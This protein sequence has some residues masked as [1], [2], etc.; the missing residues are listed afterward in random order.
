MKKLIL[1]LILVLITGSLIIACPKCKIIEAKSVCLGADVMVKFQATWSA[2]DDDCPPDGAIRYSVSYDENL[3]SANSFSS[4]TIFNPPQGS[5]TVSAQ[6]S[7]TCQDSSGTFTGWGP[8]SESASFDV[9]ELVYEGHTPCGYEKPTKDFSAPLNNGDTISATIS[10]KPSGY[11][12]TFDLIPGDIEKD[13]DATIDKDGKITMG[14][15]PGLMNFEVSIDLFKEF[16][17]SLGLGYANCCDSGKAVFYAPKK[18]TIKS[19]CDEECYKE[20][21]NTG[22][23]VLEM[24][25]VFRKNKNEINID[26]KIADDKATISFEIE[27][28]PAGFQDNFSVFTGN[29]GEGDPKVDVGLNYS[30]TEAI[31]KI[32]AV[33]PK[34]TCPCS[35]KVSAIVNAYSIDVGK[36]SPETVKDNPIAGSGFEVEALEKVDTRGDQTENEY[37]DD[38]HSKLSI[39][40]D[41]PDTDYKVELNILEGTDFAKLINETGDE[42]TEISENGLK[43]IN[44]KVKGIKYSDIKNN[45]KTK[46]KLTHNSIITSN[47]VDGFMKTIVET[48]TWDA[49][50]VNNPRPFVEITDITFVDAEFVLVKG[51]IKDWTGAF[52]RQL[53]NNEK[54]NIDSVLS[55][56]DISAVQHY[57]ANWSATVPIRKGS[58]TTFVVTAVFQNILSN[59]GSSTAVISITQNDQGE[60]INAVKSGNSNNKPNEFVDIHTFTVE[61]Y[62]ALGDADKPSFPWLLKA[63]SGDTE[64]VEADISKVAIPHYVSKKYALM[65]DNFTQEKPE[66]VLKAKPGDRLINLMECTNEN[67]AEYTFCKGIYIGLDEPI[68]SIALKPGSEINID[69]MVGGEYGDETTM[70]LQSLYSSNDQI[71]TFELK[72]TRGSIEK[73]S[74]DYHKYLNHNSAPL[75]VWDGKNH[76]GQL[77]AEGGGELKIE[78]DGMLSEEP[79]LHMEI[80]TPATAKDPVN[81]RPSSISWSNNRD[82]FYDEPYKNK[83]ELIETTNKNLIGV[84]VTN[85]L[86]MIELESDLIANDI[87]ISEKWVADEKIY[88]AQIPI[89]GVVRDVLANIDLEARVRYVSA[90]NWNNFKNFME[91]KTIFLE[92]MRENVNPSKPNAHISFFNKTLTYELKEGKNYIRIMT[93]RNALGASSDAFYLIHTTLKIVDLNLNTTEL[94]ITNIEVL[95]N[96]DNSIQWSPYFANI[97]NGLLAEKSVPENI[98]IFGAKMLTDQFYDIVSRGYNFNE[99]KRNNWSSEVFVLLPFEAKKPNDEYGQ[100]LGGDISQDKGFISSSRQDK[101]I[102][103]ANNGK[104]ELNETNVFAVDLSIESIKPVDE[105][106]KGFFMIKASSQS[107]TQNCEPEATIVKLKLSAIIKELIKNKKGDLTLSLIKSKKT[108]SVAFRLEL[109]KNGMKFQEIKTF[110]DSIKINDENI[111]SIRVL[112]LENGVADL[113]LSYK[114]ESYYTQDILRLK[115][116][117]LSFIKPFGDYNGEKDI[118]ESIKLFEP[119]AFFLNVT[120]EQLP[121]SNEFIVSGSV[122]DWSGDIESNCLYYNGIPLPNGARFELLSQL[123]LNGDGKSTE[124]IK[125]KANFSFKTQIPNGAKSNFTFDLTYKNKVGYISEYISKISFLRDKNQVIDQITRNDIFQHPKQLD[126]V[127]PY[128]YR[129]Y[130]FDPNSEFV[131]NT[132][133]SYSINGLSGEQSVI[134]EPKPWLSSNHYSQ[135]LVLIADGSRGNF[136]VDEM[137]KNLII[138]WPGAKMEVSYKQQTNQKISN[139]SIA[140]G[141][142]TV[143]SNKTRPI[144][145]VISNTNRNLKEN[146]FTNN[147]HLVG[148]FIKAKCTAEPKIII[149]AEPLKDQLTAIFFP[150]IQDLT[151]EQNLILKQ[152]GHS[153]NDEDFYYYELEP[154][155]GIMAVHM[156]DYPLQPDIIPIFSFYGFIKFKSD[157]YEVFTKVLRTDILEGDEKL[158]YMNTVFDYVSF[159]NNKPKITNFNL[160]TQG[161]MEY[162]NGIATQRFSLDIV[163]EDAL[164]DFTSDKDGRLA[165]VVI[166]KNVLKLDKDIALVRPSESRPYPFSK[167]VFDEVKLELKEG[168]NY[169]LL[170]TGENILQRDAVLPIKIITKGVNKKLVVDKILFDKN[171]IDLN[172]NQK[173]FAFE[174]AGGVRL[175]QDQNKQI[176]VNNNAIRLG[177]ENRAVN[178]FLNNTYSDLYTSGYHIFTPYSAIKTKNAPA[179]NQE[180]L[181]LPYIWQTVGAPIEI[182]TYGTEGVPHH[183]ADFAIIRLQPTTV[184]K[185]VLSDERKIAIGLFTPLFIRN[186]KEKFE[187]RAPY[188]KISFNQKAEFD[189]PDAK[190]ILSLVG[191]NDISVFLNEQEILSKNQKTFELDK[192]KFDSSGI[193][194][195][196]FYVLAYEKGVSYIKAEFQRKSS[197]YNSNEF[198]V[199]AHDFIRL[200]NWLDDFIDLDIDSDNNNYYDLPNRITL[201]DILE[202]DQ[203]LPGKYVA[204]NNDDLDYDGIPDYADGFNADGIKG[205]ADDRS[206]GVEFI[207]L[208]LEVPKDIQLKDVSIEFKYNHSGKI[209]IKREGDGSKLNPYSFKNETNSTMRIWTKDGREIRNKNAVNDKDSG[210]FVPPNVVYKDIT[211]LGFKGEQRTITLY[212]EG[213]LAKNPDGEEIKVIMTNLNGVESEDSVRVLIYDLRLGTDGDRDQTIDFAKAIDQR[214]DFWL[215]D[216]MDVIW[217]NTKEYVLV[218]DAEIVEDDIFGKEKYT[219][220]MLKDYQTPWIGQK[221]EWEVINLK[222]KTVEA[223]CLRD[224]EDFAKLKLG[225]VNKHLVNDNTGFYLKVRRPIASDLSIGVF[226]AFDETLDYLI[227]PQAGKDQ[228]LEKKLFSINNN[229]QKLGKD[230]FNFNSDNFFLFEGEHLG[231]GQLVFGIK[232][233]GKVLSE[234]SIPI[235]LRDIKSYYQNYKV[236][237]SNFSV[238]QQVNN[239]FRNDTPNEPVFVYVH[240][241]NMEGVDALWAETIYKRL[242]WQKFNGH[243]CLFDWEDLG[244]YAFDNSEENAWNSADAL[245]NTINDIRKR[246]HQ[247]E[248]VIL[249]HSQGNIVVGEYLRNYLNN[250][251]ISIKAYISTQGA[252]SAHLYD[253]QIPDFFT[254]IETPNIYGYYTDGVAGKPYMFENVSKTRIYNFYNDE[255]WALGWW[256]DANILRPNNLKGYHYSEGDGILNTYFPEFGDAFKQYFTKLSLS[257]RQER[258]KIFAQCSES[259][260]LAIGAIKLDVKGF[261]GKFDLQSNVGY[262]NQHYSH[263][264]QFRSNIIDENLFW[265]EVFEILNQ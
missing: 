6:L 203:K 158:D 230:K 116:G 190:I 37:S 224:L 156:K 42:V 53:V 85:V 124:P 32:F 135:R 136:N 1:I 137:N 28:E 138:G 57:E 46:V 35:V 133:I 96:T 206:I 81:K 253:N 120:F 107:N 63:S 208:V 131:E 118:V 88:L 10:T 196:L 75:Y 78:F 119:K 113:K 20:V 79:V 3:K 248:I 22:D 157:D 184:L 97:R 256:Q 83:I 168:E 80:L 212:I 170:R 144:F 166:G 262:K 197:Y 225:K 215:N 56:L 245:R 48:K 167:G 69:A 175:Y 7:G 254:N 229:E 90:L 87:V 125:S 214:I 174:L 30:F 76:D 181:N 209:E 179:A 93:G 29:V 94:Q 251:D 163:V 4:F 202:A 191:S 250:K 200:E 17:C 207:P 173:K 235:E 159:A 43:E 252:V 5:H 117:E 68:V 24:A 232:L 244:L 195:S 145:S 132:Q 259:R 228:I 217:P 219:P 16:S 152:Q 67:A 164:S 9:V 72:Y 239:S 162:P 169:I 61:V 249:G 89:K 263:S 110:I 255:D 13:S 140:T 188:F 64:E 38:D 82:E 234:T 41:G 199:V 122:E 198:Q 60:I 70:S 186:D 187:D 130:L 2:S 92:F 201:E 11:E 171:S 91:Q 33:K 153:H 105:A 114:Y 54:I 142:M 233:N 108:P 205:N 115:V 52:D 62:D 102:V 50:I 59:F 236:Q 261:A 222:L 264:R 180:V 148:G 189:N 45:F 51:T 74:I 100:D 36:Q 192:T 15:K 216:D 134:V 223:G 211:A 151:K 14:I 242:Y 218:N 237:E 31:G 221:L 58:G 112:G 66:Y 39:K 210:D 103:Q 104:L 226:K 99:N 227:K 129:V 106:D 34:N 241:W 123:N 77:K 21:T 40:F 143:D 154:E 183:S 128:L 165:Y 44:L 260:S 109:M 182:N 265:E 246:G 204:V 146:N 172:I 176:L 149:K 98:S 8:F 257:I 84:A 243:V 47:C 185:E 220:F 121:Y 147:F 139:I 141:I 213:L 19:A 86:P 194:S 71:G 55:S 161:E 231:K 160:K 18:L 95:N 127:K 150:K 238:V 178:Y 26:E 111:D 240:G 12:Y 23:A 25:V 126:D 27:T 258:C 177:V 247:G 49:P 101:I 65:L 73:L 155:N 193:Y